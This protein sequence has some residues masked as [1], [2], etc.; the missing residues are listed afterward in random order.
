MQEFE[1]FSSCLLL[2]T[3][4]IQ[5][6]CIIFMSKCNVCAAYIIA[7]ITMKHT[8]RPVVCYI[9]MRV[10][11]IESTR[12]TLMHMFLELSKNPELVRSL[13]SEIDSVIGMDRPPQ[14]ADKSVTL[15][16]FSLPRY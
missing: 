2:L 12:R 1:W 9:F 5:R 6:V 14:L 16:H 10:T 11:G 8:E 3:E 15:A 13:Q 7:M 4:E